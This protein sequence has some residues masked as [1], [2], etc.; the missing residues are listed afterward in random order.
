MSLNKIQEVEQGPE[1]NPFT[2]LKSIFEDYQQYV[3]IDPEK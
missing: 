1:E 3:N 2:F